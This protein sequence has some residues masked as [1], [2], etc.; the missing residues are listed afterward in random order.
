MQNGVLLVWAE[1]ILTRNS[2]PVIYF[3]INHVVF[4]PI[5]CL[6]RLTIPSY[7]TGHTEHVAN[8]VCCRS[9]MANPPIAKT[10]TSCRTPH[11]N[12][13]IMSA[14]ASQITSLMIVYSIVYSRHRSKK[15]SKLRV[16]GL[17]EGNS[18]VTMN[19]PHKG[20]VTRKMFP[21]DD[22]IMR[23]FLWL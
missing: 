2:P 12:D 20:S 9:E 22:V 11:Y 21:F 8:T 17:C 19:S 18:P 23:T 3:S 13:V 10:S 4:V 6:H 16:T 14:M 7:F 1:W 5:V 15:A